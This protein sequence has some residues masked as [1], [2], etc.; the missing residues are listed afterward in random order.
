ML[1]SYH[2]YCKWDKHSFPKATIYYWLSVKL[3]KIK[4]RQ[5]YKSAKWFGFCNYKGRFL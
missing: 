2:T 3:S 4:K 5:Q 1:K